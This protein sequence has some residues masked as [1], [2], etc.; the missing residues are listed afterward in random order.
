MIQLSESKTVWVEESESDGGE[1][2]V[3]IL[4]GDKQLG[5]R[6][7]ISL[8]PKEAMNLGSAINRCA[9]IIHLRGA[10]DIPDDKK[11]LDS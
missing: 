4:Y 7:N 10:K 5:V 6:F 1:P 3:S 9:L 11:S 8:T 2:E